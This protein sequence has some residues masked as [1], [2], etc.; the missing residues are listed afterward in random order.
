MFVHLANRESLYPRSLGSYQR[1]QEGTFQEPFFHAE[2]VTFDLPIAPDFLLTG[3]FDGDL[4]TD[5]LVASRAE[6][7]VYLLSNDGP[8]GLRS[9]KHRQLEGHP[10]ALVSG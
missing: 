2:A 3:D 5:V 10:T 8:G 4:R 9:P 6:A 1:I 7:A